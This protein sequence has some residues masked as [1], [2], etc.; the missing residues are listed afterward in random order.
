VILEAIMS[1]W[2]LT[3]MRISL[4]DLLY[5]VLLQEGQ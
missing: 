4:A 1:Y 2:Q 5:G 3:G